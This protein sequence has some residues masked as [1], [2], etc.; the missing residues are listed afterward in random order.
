MLPTPQPVGAILSV[1]L[2]HE[3]DDRFTVLD[4]PF[5]MVLEYTCM[6]MHA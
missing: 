4:P 1:R 6:R 3:G 5:D 2:P